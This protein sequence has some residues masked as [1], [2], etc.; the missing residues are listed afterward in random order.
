MLGH[1]SVC[2][3]TRPMFWHSLSY[4]PSLVI[5]SFWHPIPPLAT[6]QQKSDGATASAARAKEAALDTLPLPRFAQVFS[7]FAAGTGDVS[8]S[9]KRAKT[10]DSREFT[11]VL[12]HLQLLPDRITCAFFFIFVQRWLFCTYFFVDI[13]ACVSPCICMRT[14]INVHICVYT[15]MHIFLIC[16]YDEIYIHICVWI[17]A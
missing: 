16:I 15:Y 7:K 6:E 12:E 3:D 17:S 8:Q 1:S 4:L 14:H 13:F 10:L 9:K 5:C 11:A 2:W